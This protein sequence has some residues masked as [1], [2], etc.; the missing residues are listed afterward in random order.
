M[1]TKAD[2]YPIHQTPDPIA[3]AGTDRNFYDRYFFNGYAT[4]GDMFFAA[5]LGVY[6]QL[7]IIDA[8]F[9]VRIGGVQYNLHASRHLGMERMDTEVGPIRIEV[10]EP[11]Q[12]LRLTVDDKAHGIEADLVFDGRHKVIEEPRMTRRNGPRMLMDFTRL[13][14]LGSYSGWIRAGGREI[15]AEETRFLGTRDRSWGVRAVGLRDPQPMVPQPPAQFH[16]YWVP[17]QLEDRII[18]FYLNEDEQGTTW[19][20]GLV[21]CHD[22]GSIEHLQNAAIDADLHP[23]TRW[24]RHG[25]ITAKDA[26]GGHYRIEV[27]PE[28]RFYLSGLGYLNPDWGHGHNKGERAIGYDELRAEDVDSYR[29]PYVHAEAFARLTLTAPDGSSVHGTGTFETLSMGPNAGRGLTGLV[30]A[31]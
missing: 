16:W 30:D 3:F 2:D 12:R 22:D 13:T 23:G 24:P 9:G 17:A 14:Q 1:L 29:M 19:N 25:L 27:K 26:R 7:N 18:H 31:P 8:A 10:L 5:A 6:P 21:M 11:L 4:D 20:R 15:R 28:A